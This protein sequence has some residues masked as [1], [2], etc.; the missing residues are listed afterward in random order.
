MVSEEIS[1]PTVE[2]LGSTSDGGF[3]D[4]DDLIDS[5]HGNFRF[6]P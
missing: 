5:A 6:A 3:R 2:L 1:W 4:S